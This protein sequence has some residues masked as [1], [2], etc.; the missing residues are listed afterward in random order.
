M[1]M[2]EEA[3]EETV[4]DLIGLDNNVRLRQSKELKEQILQD[5]RF[6]EWYDKLFG[7]TCSTFTTHSLSQKKT[8]CSRSWPTWLTGWTVAL[9]AGPHLNRGVWHGR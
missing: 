6:D 5:G 9:Y 2:L 4:Q 1:A 7:T 8:H 3:V